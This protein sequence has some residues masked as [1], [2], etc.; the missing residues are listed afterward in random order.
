MILSVWC[1]ASM[2]V[3]LK[4]PELEKFVADQVKAGFFLSSEAAVE[5]SVTQ[6]MVDQEA[7]SLIERDIAEIDTSETEIDRGDSGDF[8]KFAPAA[9][10]TTQPCTSG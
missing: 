7:A 2:Q 5:A 10:A 8:D 4:K 3:H 9:T 6:M 1:A